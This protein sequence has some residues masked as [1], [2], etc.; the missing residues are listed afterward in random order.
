MYSSAEESPAKIRDQRQHPGSNPGLS[1]A[2]I[3]HARVYIHMACVINSSSSWIGYH[4][5]DF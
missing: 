1:I 5:E 4:Q 2:R 3:D